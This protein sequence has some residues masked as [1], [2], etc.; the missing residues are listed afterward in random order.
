[1]RHR[2][3]TGEPQPSVERYL[4]LGHLLHIIAIH[5]FRARGVGLSQ[6]LGRDG[7][8]VRGT[9]LRAGLADLR[10]LHTVLLLRRDGGLVRGTC[11]RAGLAG[12]RGLH[13]AERKGLGNICAVVNAQ[14]VPC[15][16]VCHRTCTRTSLGGAESDCADCQDSQEAELDPVAAR[17]LHLVALITVFDPVD[18][19]RVRC[20]RNAQYIR[21]EGRL[22]LVLHRSMLVRTC[23]RLCLSQSQSKSENENEKLFFADWPPGG[24]FYWPRA[25]H[26]VKFDESHYD[27]SSLREDSRDGVKHARVHIPQIRRQL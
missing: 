26:R 16:R 25:G 13:R 7:G 22:P 9:C 8:L 17:N 23:E 11:L 19:R 18:V 27:G 24:L 3:R 4:Q 6:L 10:A 12:L 15:G 1:M 20:A 21:R 2:T 5:P 14:S